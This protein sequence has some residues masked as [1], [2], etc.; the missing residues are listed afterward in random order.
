MSYFGIENN[1]AVACCGS[2]VSAYHIH[3]LLDAGAK[4]IVIAMDRQFKEIGDEEFI[5][6]TNKIK[7]IK[8]KYGNRIRITAIFDKEMITPYKSSPID[9]GRE[10]FEYLLEN[11]IKDF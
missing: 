8:K 2:N 6:L 11:R 5:R 4:E 9:Q 7:N 10:I 1:I 3:Q